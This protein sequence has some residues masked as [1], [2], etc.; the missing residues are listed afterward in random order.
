MALYEQVS[1][2]TQQHE[3]APKPDND[4][5]DANRQTPNCQQQ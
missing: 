4:D 2:N 3:E 1:L 5:D